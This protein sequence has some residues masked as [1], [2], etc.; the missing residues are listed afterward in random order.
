MKYAPGKGINKYN[1]DWSVSQLGVAS[2]YMGGA[3]MACLNH[4]MRIVL[5]FF[6]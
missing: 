3:E 5:I 1:K 6:R 4:D 2:I